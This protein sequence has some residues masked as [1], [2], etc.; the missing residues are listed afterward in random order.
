MRTTHRLVFSP[1]QDL[2][3]LASN[4]VELVV[5]S[6]PYPMIGMWD[7]ALA[8][9]SPAVAEA[10]QANEGPKAFEGMHQ[11]LDRVWEELYRVCRPGGIV[12]INI[13]DATRSLAGDF[14]LYPNHARVLQSCLRLGFSNLPNI[15]WR[16][17]TNAPNKFMGAGMLAPGAYVTLEH[18]HI[19]IFRKGSK[20]LFK[21]PEEKQNRQRSAFFWEERNVWFSD[22]WEMKG[23]GQK[24]NEQNN[25]E[26]SAA[27]PFELAYRLINMFSVKKDT[28]LDPFLGTGTTALAALAAGRNSI[29]YEIDVRLAPHIQAALA[30]ESIPAL[31]HYIHSRL[32]RHLDFVRERTFRK[33]TDAFRHL[34]STYGFPVMTSQ[35]KHLVF[36]YLQSVKSVD[37]LAVEAEYAP[38]PSLSLFYPPD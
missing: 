12:C 11:E 8:A 28:V 3:A 15:L 29:G 26:R 36:H 32:Q 14:R 1:A 22:V 5:T 23:A 18:E 19:L 25:R 24:L 6:P 10:L 13:G 35:E 7:E 38:F 20:R 2:S 16:K 30:A 9:Q 34:N 31:N 21:T 27:F 17:N 33:G 4:S 37:N